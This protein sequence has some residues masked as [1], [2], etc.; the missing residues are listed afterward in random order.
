MRK[1]M[2][3]AIPIVSIILFIGIMLSDIFIKSPRLDGDVIPESIEELIQIVQSENWDEA[4]IKAKDLDIAWQKFVKL[5]QFSSE[6]E[7]IN[8]FNV[9]LARLEGAILEK[10]KAGAV[11][12]LKEAYEH[13]DKLG[14]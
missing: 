9:N 6:R 7:E 3:I 14:Q 1:F 11:I 2:V 12:E 8:F 13:W 5:V 4:A 10:D